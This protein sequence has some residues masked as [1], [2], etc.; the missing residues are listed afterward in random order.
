MTA[1]PTPY[2]SEDEYIARERAAESK[3]EYLRGEVFAMAGGSPRHNLITA[4]IAR[5][6]P[7]EM[8]C[9]VLS[10]DQRVHVVEPKGG[11]YTYPDVTVVCGPLEMHPRW[12]ENLLN[13]TVLFEVLSP[14]TEAYDRGAK[15]AHYR[16]I[17][18]LREYVLVS[19][20]EPFVEHF[21]RVGE[22]W[23]LTTYAPPATHVTLP[24]LR[25]T[26]ALADIYARVE[27]LAPYPSPVADADPEGYLP[28][29]KVLS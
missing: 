19:Q 6:F 10:S 16:R 12:S 22:R 11:L 2:V 9:A 26:L 29:P 8:P 1:A 27:L 17:P 25:V 4:N 21:E 5:A 23:T 24:S 3:S 13:P 20:V 28:R 14:S 7:K 18:S 15:F